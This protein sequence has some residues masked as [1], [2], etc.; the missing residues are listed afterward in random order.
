MINK[1]VVYTKLSPNT[2]LA[3]GEIEEYYQEFTEDVGL[4]AVIRTVES[5]RGGGAFKF[6]L[7]GYTG[8][9]LL[10]FYGDFNAEEMAYLAKEATD[11]KGVST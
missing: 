5:E 2:D 8:N 10:H 3:S 6:V 7:K 11:W 1:L 9:I 4:A